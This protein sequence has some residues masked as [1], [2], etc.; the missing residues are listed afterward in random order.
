[1]S[2]SE[3]G[4]RAGSGTS[5]ATP[6][7]EIR[8]TNFRDSKGPAACDDMVNPVLNLGLPKRIGR[9]REL[10]YNLWWSWHPQARELFRALD[11]PLWRMSG[12]NPVKQLHEI[13]PDRLR[14]EAADPAFLTLYDAVMSAFDA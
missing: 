1:M 8:D 12:H 7:R 14:E 11:Y 13:S 2:A 9:L 6:V 5:L 10:A 3:D 4:C